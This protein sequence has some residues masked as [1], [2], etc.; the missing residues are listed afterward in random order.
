MSAFPR[1]RLLLTLGTGLLGTGAYGLL[2]QLGAAGDDSTTNDAGLKMVERSSHALGS[3]VRFTV[4]HPDAAAADKAISAALA[5][6]DLIEDLMSLYRPGSQLCR[7]NRAGALDEPH[8][9]LVEVLQAAQAMSDRTEGAFDVTVQPLWDAYLQAAQENRLPADTAIEAAHQLVD[10]W[11]LSVGASQIRLLRPGA[12]VT[13]NGIAQG[14]AAD[15][16]QAVLRQ[17]GIEHALVDA[18][19]LAPLGQKPRDQA[20]TAA[21]QHPREPDAY[22]A[23]ARLDGRCLATSGD[24]AS[25]FG[26][27]RRDHHI[28]DPRTGRSPTELASVSIAAPSAMLAD[29][30][31]TA[32]FVLGPERGLQ[33]IE[34]YQNTDALLV[35]KDG[36][37]VSTEGFPSV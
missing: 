30:L 22:I 7:L 28:F 21:I 16:A 24:Y 13:L 4:L 34:R 25:S 36:R 26:S 27:D 23:L 9:Y 5:E 17:H 3:A 15:R 14:F 6:L 32:V 29:A 31:S 8:P 20:W 2:R 37:V 18:G 11:Q 35:H 19:E 1:R 10:W 33:L 12:A